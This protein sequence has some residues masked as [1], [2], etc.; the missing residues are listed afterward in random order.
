MTKKI[1]YSAIPEFERDMKKLSKS[2]STLPDDMETAKK[3]AIELYHINNQ[4]NNAIFPMPEFCNDTVI[5]HKIRKF[6]CRSL[7]GRGAMSGI[8]VIYAY[9][10]ADMRVVFIEIYFKANKENEDRERIKSFLRENI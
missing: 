6:A 10:P 5:V 2:F 4:D 1:T 8:R 7:K 9:F 3:A